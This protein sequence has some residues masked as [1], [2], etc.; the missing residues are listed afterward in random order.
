MT[1]NEKKDMDEYVY[2]LFLVLVE[3]FEQ[4]IEDVIEYV[5]T[6]TVPEMKYLLK[7][8]MDYILLDFILWYHLYRK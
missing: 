5:G 6:L 8:Q 7:H 4:R 3:I 1:N 2:Q